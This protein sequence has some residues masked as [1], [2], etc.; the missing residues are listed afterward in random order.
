MDPVRGETAGPTAAAARRQV[1]HD[2]GPGHGDGG[3]LWARFRRDSA[4]DSLEVVHDQHPPTP[5]HAQNRQFQPPTTTANDTWGVRALLRRVA[6]KLPLT[7]RT[8]CL[9]LP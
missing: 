4:G 8:G 5:F 9:P 1:D 7:R 3:D 6:L 2:D